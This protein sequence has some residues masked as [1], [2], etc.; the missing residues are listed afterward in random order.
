MECR[1]GTRIRFMEK[2]KSYSDQYG[3]SDA[4]VLDLSGIS[5]VPAGKYRGNTQIKV[6]LL[7]CSR[8]KIG[9]EAFADCTSLERITVPDGYEKRQVRDLEKWIR[10]GKKAFA[11]CSSLKLVKMGP[12]TIYEQAFSGCVSLESVEIGF[13]GIERCVFENCP[14]LASFHVSARSGQKDGC[15][16]GMRFPEKLLDAENLEDIIDSLLDRDLELYFLNETSWK[17]LN[18]LRQAAVYT[19]LR[20]KYYRKRFLRLLPVTD[21]EALA[22]MFLRKIESLSPRKQAIA[23]AEFLLV[24]AGRLPDSLFMDFYRRAVC[25]GYSFD[26]KSEVLSDLFIKERKQLIEQAHPDHHAK[27]PADEYN[28][29]Y[30]AGSLEKPEKL[31][32]KGMIETGISLA[33]LQYFTEEHIEK[34]DNI[35]L[36]PAAG[37]RGFLRPFVLFW[38]LSVH[39]YTGY[40]ALSEQTDSCTR[41]KGIFPVPVKKGLCPQ[42]KSLLPWIEQEAFRLFLGRLVRRKLEHCRETGRFEQLS[43]QLVFY[44]D[45]FSRFADRNALLALEK[46]LQKNMEECV[47][48]GMFYRSQLLSALAGSEEPAASAILKKQEET[49]LFQDFLSGREYPA[50]DWKETFLDHPARLDLI[51]GLIWAQDG[52]TFLARQSL[53]R[54]VHLLD[55]H[56]R[57]IRLAESPV[58]LAHPLEMTSEEIRLW[59]AY[60]KEE[61]IEQPFLQIEEP[62][63]DPALLQE[64]R[65]DGCL[66]HSYFLKRR[67]EDGIFFQDAYTFRTMDTFAVSDPMESQPMMLCLTDCIHMDDDVPEEAE[68][69]CGYYRGSEIRKYQDQHFIWSVRKKALPEGKE[70]YS[71]TELFEIDSDMTME[72]LGEKKADY[73]E[74]FHPDL[75][76]PR[77]LNSGV[78]TTEREFRNQKNR[79]IN[80]HRFRF[81][82]FNRHVNHIAAYLDRLTLPGRICKDDPDI[83]RQL[84]GLSQAS[85]QELIKMA[86]AHKAYRALSV[87]MD[88]HNS[89][90]GAVDPGEVFDI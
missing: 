83:R 11:G 43:G 57:E 76:D 3:C 6:I 65:Y 9:E 26:K 22:P 19:A 37:R 79:L 38:L 71:R 42:A 12:A 89:V 58:R 51:R 44:A 2:K 53:D 49:T 70:I 31:A 73:P 78:Y 56:S 47:F 75:F 48:A 18:A 13:S 68:G 46:D 84:T 54:K 39:V 80:L 87:L 62:A 64:D 59:R 17:S 52:K 74:V 35:P 25:S 90:F 15:W 23:A 32:L 45:A 7:P 67:Q 86:R 63:A 72:L 1:R 34:W 60:L 8:L 27:D 61:G 69:I 36:L 50:G 4:A 29:G 16:F 81:A 40:T 85:I 33:E 66:F 41:K 30:P 55:F 88:F 24:Y 10:F 14:S 5:Q 20:Q 82:Q 28:T 21:P 77:Q